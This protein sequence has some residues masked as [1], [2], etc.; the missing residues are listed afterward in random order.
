MEFCASL[1]LPA[2]RCA[3][4]AGS[5]VLAS[6]QCA[7]ARG[8]GPILLVSTGRTTLGQNA[9][10]PEVLLHLLRLSSPYA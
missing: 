2:F 3:N 4:D 9:R 1:A 8:G 6:T 10:P 5:P 7:E